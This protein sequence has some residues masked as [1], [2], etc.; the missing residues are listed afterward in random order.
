MI[1][2]LGQCVQHLTISSYHDRLDHVADVDAD[3]VEMPLEMIV[4]II[5]VL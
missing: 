4:V 5:L 3:D 1:I 2:D